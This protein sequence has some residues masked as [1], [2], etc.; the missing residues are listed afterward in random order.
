MDE[1]RLWMDDREEPLSQSGK[2]WKPAGMNGLPSRLRYVSNFLPPFA[3]S[4]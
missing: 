1:R 2:G 3:S 4:R